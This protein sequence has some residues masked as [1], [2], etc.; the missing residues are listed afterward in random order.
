MKNLLEAVRLVAFAVYDWL[1]A[2]TDCTP[3]KD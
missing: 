3:L 2:P 1:F